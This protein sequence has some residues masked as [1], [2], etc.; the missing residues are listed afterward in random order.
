[1]ATQ[2]VQTQLED[3]RLMSEEH[4]AIARAV[5]VAVRKLPGPHVEAVK[6]GGI[7][8]SAGSVQFGGVF[9]YKAHVSVEFGHGAAI[10]DTLGYLEG[11]GKGRRHL[12]L[13]SLDDIKAKHVAQ[14]LPMALQAA[15]RADQESP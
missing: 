3:I 11:G 4:Y 9:V 14:Y 1:M 10:N 13:T 12:K 6:Y 8:F 5:L 2:S 15:Q 7:L